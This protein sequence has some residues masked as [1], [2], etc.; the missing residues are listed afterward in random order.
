[1][2]D[3]ISFVVQVLE[4]IIYIYI[5]YQL[6]DRK[7]TIK[8]AIIIGIFLGGFWSICNIYDLQGVQ[9]LL[10][11]R[12]F[13][14][15]LI[16]ISSRENIFKVIICAFIS[17]NIS[18]M[19]EYTIMATITLGLDI[20][21]Q[22]FFNN[23]L[24]Y[25]LV[26]L[27]SF[28]IGYILYLILKKYRLTMYDSNQNYF[29]VERTLSQNINL[30]TLIKEIS[31]GYNVLIIIFV[32]QMTLITYYFKSKEFFKLLASDN[33]TNI[34][35]QTIVISIIIFLLNLMTVFMARRIQKVK[36]ENYHNKIREM[37]FSQM[38]KENFI[39]RQYKH[40]LYNHFKLLCALAEE[41]KHDEVYSYLVN[42]HE[43]IKNRIII[44]RTGL[45]ELDIFLNS[46]INFAQQNNIKIDYKCFA[47]IKCN[48][49]HII[50]FIS[51]IGNLLDNAIEAS[52]K[53]EKKLLSIF[54]DEEIVHYSFII[55]NTFE[56]NEGLDPELLIQEGFSTKGNGRG[57]GLKIVDRIIKKYNGKIGLNINEDYFEVK[58]VLPKHELNRY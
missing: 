53:S 42:Y 24:I 5:V 55:K 38:E 40:D 31:N 56:N 25:F 14:I 30:L 21:I 58:V 32:I 13:M 23:S 22:T 37:E 48:N 29:S 27:I 39:I 43:D 26:Y 20:S 44:V 36:E 35:I 46:K 18:L 28:I 33:S 34:E 49:N 4:S 50:D 12:T 2:F 6:L 57:F 9:Y 7:T 16:C 15:F 8:N 10:L 1:M 52:Q 51:I 3:I 17:S 45:D 41:K 19:I 11:Y 47:S 54:I